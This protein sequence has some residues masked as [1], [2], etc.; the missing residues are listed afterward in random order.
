MLQVKKPCGLRYSVD[1]DG[2]IRV[3]SGDSATEVS[4]ELLTWQQFYRE[5]TSYRDEDYRRSSTQRK[6][7][8]G[9]FGPNILLALLIF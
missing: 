9:N 7:N 4:K 1:V 6:K 8:T 2:G 5:R 3:K